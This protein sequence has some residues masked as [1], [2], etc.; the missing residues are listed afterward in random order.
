MWILP[1]Q[2]HT[3][4]IA[5]DT[6]ALIWPSHQSLAEAWSQSL[7]RRSKCSASGTVLK[8]LKDSKR[9]HLFPNCMYHF[10]SGRT[11]KPSLSKNFTDWWTSTLR[12]SRASHSASRGSEQPITTLDTCSHSSSEES[13]KCVPELFSSKTLKGSSPPS[14]KEA[15]WQTLPE[16]R[17]CSMS[18]AN[19]RDWVTDQRQEYSRRLK[20]ACRTNGSESLCWPS[21]ASRDWK[22]AGHIS[23]ALFRKQNGHCQPLPEVVQLYSQAALES[24]NTNGSLPEQ[25]QTPEAQN[26]TGY[27]ISSG[28]K[29]LKLGSQVLEWPTPNVPNGGRTLDPK[30]A[31]NKG[32]R[33]DGTKAQVGLENA[34]ALWPTP[35]TLTGGANT[36]RAE[37]GAGGADLQEAVQWPTPCVPGENS[38]GT[39]SEW[40]GSHN[41]LRSN[42][43]N[44]KAKLNP[45]FVELLMG[46]P[47]GW[48]MP[49]CAI[50]MTPVLMNSEHVET[51]LCQQQPQKPL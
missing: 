13:A 32:T 34:V 31:A 19:W 14:S 2:F 21:P 46:I 7:L 36:K 49:T 5:M 43:K 11:L 10:L 41:L 15:D 35:K 6:E 17:F 45:R 4:V 26:S 29:I 20:L 16:P 37:R 44:H 12:A 3:S 42:P 48:T 9:S 24:R 18:S 51:V 22:A 38:I 25:W 27:H 1:K 28:K 47:I 50:P 30:V 33:P 39:I 8:R 40:G 23:S